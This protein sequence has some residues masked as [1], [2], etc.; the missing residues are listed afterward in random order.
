MSNKRNRNFLIPTILFSWALI[1]CPTINAIEFPSSPKSSEPRSTAAG[2]R[3]GPCIS[4]SYPIVQAL[5]PT[6]DNYI[7]T[8]S[9]NP[10]LFVY[11]PRTDA[12]LAHFVLTDENEQVI[13]IQEI[14]INPIEST[15]NDC[16]GDY[17]AK[18]NLP[19]NINLQINQK[20]SWE[21]FLFDERL[22]KDYFFN[23]RKYS[24]FD[25]YK[26]VLTSNNY[27]NVRKFTNIRN[28]TKG[29]LERVTLASDI[30]GQ[31]SQENMAQ[32]AE[33]YAQ[34]Q[35]WAETL[36]LVV[37]LR[38]SRPEMWQE[39]LTSVGLEKYAEKKFQ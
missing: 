11:L 28:N 37:A 32:Q 39:L 15:N 38:Q 36:S 14:N 26:E 18:I 6:N 10:P 33:I 21:L 25:E 30:A 31:I 4:N 16:S 8:T 24:N 7:K 9:T 3:R 19:Q 23:S 20:Y 13:T 5:T 29:T 34:E 35:I 12:K 22:T 1:Y 17:V 2:G 27:Q